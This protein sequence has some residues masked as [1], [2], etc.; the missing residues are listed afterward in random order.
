MQGNEELKK[1]QILSAQIDLSKFNKGDFIKATEE[2]KKQQD[3]MGESTTFFKDGMKRLK[4]N[5]LAMGSIVILVLI[6]A[7]NY[8]KLL[9]E[10]AE[11]YILLGVLVYTA[12]AAFSMGASQS[13]GNIFKSW[14][15]ML[16]GQFF[17]LLMNAWCLRLFTSM[18]GT[19]LANPLSL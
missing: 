7:W 4:K 6:L 19:F 5:P 14:C 3:V 1:R 2:E 8:I 13:T 9:F 12:P 17:L 10:A 18:V 15:R 16:G 11:R